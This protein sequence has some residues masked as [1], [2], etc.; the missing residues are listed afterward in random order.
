MNINC[1]DCILLGYYFIN[2]TDYEIRLIGKGGTKGICIPMFLI[3]FSCLI[4]AR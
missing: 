4:L 2:A 1:N 3:L